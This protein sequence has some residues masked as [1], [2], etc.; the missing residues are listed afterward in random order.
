MDDEPSFLIPIED[1]WPSQEEMDALLSQHGRKKD[2]E[3]GKNG[4]EREAS[5]EKT[6]SNNGGISEG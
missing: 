6:E 4:Q 1:S 2:F 5:K 3:Y